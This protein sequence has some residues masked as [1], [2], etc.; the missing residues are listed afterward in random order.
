MFIKIVVV[1][2]VLN[3]IYELVEMIFPVKTLNLTIKSFA[4]IVMLY[5]LC[6]YVVAVI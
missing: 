2:I 4:L 3:V 6:D 1:V 5:A